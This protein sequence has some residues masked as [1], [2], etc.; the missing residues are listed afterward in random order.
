MYWVWYVLYI[1]LYIHMNVY[2]CTLCGRVRVH[3]YNRIWKPTYYRAKVMSCLMSKCESGD[4]SWNT[5]AIVEQTH[6][7]S[8]QCLSNTTRKCLVALTNTTW[9]WRDEEEGREV[10]V[11]KQ[12][13]HQ[14]RARLIAFVSVNTPTCPS[15]WIRLSSNVCQ[16]EHTIVKVTICEQVRETVVSVVGSWIS[17]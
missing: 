11:N 16:T 17:V 8:I 13:I 9:G 7:S 2:A 12:C 3:A 10:E 5:S 14:C 6:Y 4:T 15:S 1:C